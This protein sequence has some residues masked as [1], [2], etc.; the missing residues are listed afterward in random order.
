MFYKTNPVGYLLVVLQIDGISPF[1]R[2]A[3]VLVCLL[4]YNVVFTTILIV[5]CL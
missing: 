5:R 1:H 2:L 3:S 4:T